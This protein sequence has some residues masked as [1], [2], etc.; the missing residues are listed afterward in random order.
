M[1]RISGG[2]YPQ[3]FSWILLNKN[4]VECVCCLLCLAI[5]SCLTLCNPHG[6][7]RPQA[8]LFME[9]SRQ[10]YWIELPFP[11]PNDLP[12]PGIE[13]TFPALQADSL[14]SEPPGN[15]LITLHILSLIHYKPSNSSN[16]NSWRLKLFRIFVKVTRLARRM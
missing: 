11:L 16:G 1:G 15:F 4:K 8:R 5:Q 2:K 13:F 3:L 10:D 14:P 7:C 12:D 6:L 9:F